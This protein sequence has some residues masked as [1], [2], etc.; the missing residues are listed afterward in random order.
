MIICKKRIN[1]VDNVI[2]ITGDQDFYITF[3]CD[4]AEVKKIGFKNL[5]LGERIIPN[6][7]GTNSKLNVTTKE[8]IELPKVKEKVTHTLPYDIRDW[9]GNP[10]S[11]V[12]NRTFIRWKRKK[13]G[14]YNEQLE[15][16]QIIDDKYVISTRLISH[17]EQKQTIKYLL[18]LML[19]IG[20]A[21]ELVD[22]KTVP[23]LKSKKVN[24]K[25]L[26]P[27]NMPWDRYY[28]LT[29]RKMQK[30]TQTEIKCIKERYDFLV[31][32]DPKSIICGS[33]EFSGYFI[34][35]LNPNLYICESIFLGNAIYVLDKGWE[36]ISKLTKKEIIKG[37]L[38][39]KRIIHNGDWKK[40]LLNYISTI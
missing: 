14:C 15:I 34:A 10:H 26:P 30:Y 29:K 24:W 28:E 17:N 40:I 35:E 37:N 7:S 27:G 19:E 11:G 8:I 4:E 32:L 39:K 6:V 13:I 22:S 3:A 9:H 5:E 38:S 2:S 25:I 1:N 18:N 16:K 36:E 12:Y 33:D 31:S 20:K 21:I 23:I